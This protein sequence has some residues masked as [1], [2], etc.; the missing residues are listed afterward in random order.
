MSEEKRVLTLEDFWRLKT[1]DDPQPSPDGSQVAYVVGSFD[2]TKNQAHS[3]IWLAS[4]ENGQCRQLTSGEK[5]DTQPRWSPDGAQLAFVS[6]RHEEKPQLFLIE[7]SGGEARRLTNVPDGVSAPLW[8]PDGKQLCYTSTPETDRQKVPQESAWLEAHSDVDKNT[9]RLRR[10]SSLVSRFDMR[11]YIDKRAQLF[12]L[13]LDE[14]QAAPRQLTEG[15]FDAGQPVWSP[16]GKQ[17]AFVA[18]R[19]ANVDASLASDIW[20]LAVESGELKCLTNGELSAMFPSWSP[21]GESIAFFADYSMDTRSGYEDPHLWLVSRSGG[22][23]RDLMSHLDRS[24]SAM[25][26]DYH[27]SG[28]AKPIWSPDGQTIYFV[29]AE[30]GANA[31]FALS[32]ESGKCQRVSSTAADI[33][34]LESAGARQMF[35][36]VAAT[37]EQPYDLFTLPWSGG[38]LKPL[39]STNQ[40]LLAE[41]SIAPTERISFTGPDGWEIEGW[42][43]KPLHAEGRYPLIL[44][45]HGGPYSAWGHSFYFQ[46]Q[47]LAG[48]GY[49]SLYVNPRGSKGYNLAFTQA[50]DWGEKDFR[51][52]MAGIDAV[53]ARGEVDPQKLGITGISYGG[54]MTNWAL[55]HT[56]RFAAGV[57]VNGVSNLVSMCGTSDIS[58]LWLGTQYGRFWENEESLQFFRT[59]SPIT[60]VGNISTPLLLLQSEND[61]RCPIE[62]GEQLF[63][64]LCVR[65]QTVELIR[66]PNASHAI[67]KTASPHHRYF[68]WKLA[69]DWFEK[70]IQARS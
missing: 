11:G 5:H 27:F 50:A 52:L 37:S 28:G 16:D 34:A 4:L 70:H 8:S 46:A 10:Q 67:A 38:E 54:F 18:N 65:Q 24:L 15:D 6:T 62:Q 53:L 48:A 13:N 19:T 14:P 12:L 51:D 60:Y 44:H 26:P 42:L 31:I 45:V 22:D 3:A 29:S 47:A 49:A 21:D 63:S 32:L 2:E 58:A 59:H 57:S 55:G 30:H 56:D 35:V 7:V 66:F 20:T 40:E 1:V 61:Y 68:Q 9:P 69:L 17:I 33:I 64:A 23:Q 39:V 36:G 43:V 41:V 25:Q